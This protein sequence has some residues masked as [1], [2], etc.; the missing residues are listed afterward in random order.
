MLYGYWRWQICF[1]LDE[2]DKLLQSLYGLSR[3]E[4]IECW[5]YKAVGQSL[6]PS[7]EDWNRYGALGKK[8]A[9]KLIGYNSCL[10]ANRR[11][12]R[13]YRQKAFRTTIDISWSETQVVDEVV[14]KYSRLRDK[15]L[16]DSSFGE[17]KNFQR[18]FE[19]INQ[20]KKYFAKGEER[21]YKSRNF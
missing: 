15:L 8:L 10:I 16:N 11:W 1:V 13:H 5:Q 21:P 9:Y 7:P 3:L 2:W 14:L 4:T 20:L 19:I 17:I 18:L 12:R 6:R